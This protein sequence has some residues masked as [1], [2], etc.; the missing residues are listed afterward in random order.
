MARRGIANYDPPGTDENDAIWWRQCVRSAGDEQ[1]YDGANAFVSSKGWSTYVNMRSTATAAFRETADA[2]ALGA[3]QQSFRAGKSSWHHTV[4]K[5][6]SVN[7]NLLSTSSQSFSSQVPPHVVTSLTHASA[8]HAKP[9]TP[10]TPRSQLTSGH[11]QRSTSFAAAGRGSVCSTPRSRSEQRATASTWAFQG[12]S[13]ANSGI[14]MGS[15]V[16][17]PRL[18]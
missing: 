12:A 18:Y 13:P 1:R 10:R 7:V 5:P 17:Y 14:L 6:A 9:P 4:F 11:S 15:Q 3:S 8:L 2:V 16:Y